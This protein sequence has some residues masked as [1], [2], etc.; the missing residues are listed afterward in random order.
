MLPLFR[1]PSGLPFWAKNQKGVTA[2]AKI[3]IVGASLSRL[4][5]ASSSGAGHSPFAAAAAGKPFIFFP[6]AEEGPSCPRCRN[7]SWGGGGKED[8]R[9]NRRCA[10]G[11]GPSCP[12]ASRILAARGKLP[13]IWGL[14]RRTYIDVWSGL[15][16][17]LAEN[18][19]KLFVLFTFY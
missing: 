1:R 18:V 12:G 4:E 7:T 8:S 13:G 19:S 5:K 6:L 3:I 10:V 9:R 17:H 14:T 11:G 16:R 15:W 2:R